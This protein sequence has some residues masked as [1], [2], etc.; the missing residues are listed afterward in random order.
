MDISIALAKEDMLGTDIMYWE[1]DLKNAVYQVLP[2]DHGMVFWNIWQYS[3]LVLFP[4]WKAAASHILYS[5]SGS[6]HNPF[7]V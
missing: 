7:F 3:L 1:L 6:F 4:T 5:S 2:R